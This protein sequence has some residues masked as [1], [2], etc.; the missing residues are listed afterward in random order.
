M[1]P[2]AVTMLFAARWP[3]ARCP[4]RLQ[5]PTH[6]GQRDRSSGYVLLAVAHDQQWSIY[7]STAVLGVGVGFAF[8]AL[9]NLVVQA[10]DPRQTGEATGINTIMRTIGGSLGAQIAATIV[11][12]ARSPA[13]RSR[14]VRLHAAFVMS[15]IAMGLAA[16]AALAGPGRLGKRHATPATQDR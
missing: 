16:L 10:V 15:A 3:A 13:R 8:A 4:R 6:P 1:V 9:T 14:R 5:A 11:T 7:L 2:M 12:S